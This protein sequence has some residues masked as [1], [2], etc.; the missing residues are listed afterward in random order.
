M[1]DLDSL[2]RDYY[3]DTVLEIPDI[4]D[5]DIFATSPEPPCPCDEIVPFPQEV[6]R[7]RRRYEPPK[8]K[9]YSD[10]SA[11]EVVAYHEEGRQI[12]KDGSIRI[13]DS[14]LRPHHKGVI[15][16]IT[17]TKMDVTRLHPNLYWCSK[18]QFKLS[19]LEQSNGENGNPP[20]LQRI[21]K[22]EDLLEMK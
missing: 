18:N 9:L 8:E 5:A 16:E 3:D 14:I 12:P 7:R 2:E 13:D 10:R 1:K 17:Y 15:I 4:D 20:I 22:I 11:D 19:P 6:R 21:L